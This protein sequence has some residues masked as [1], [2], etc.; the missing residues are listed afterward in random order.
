MMKLTW[1]V[2]NFVDA[3]VETVEF[4]TVEEFYALP[5]IARKSA[6]PGFIRWSISDT[7]LMAEYQDES[8]WAIANLSRKAITAL[9]LPKWKMPLRKR[10][11]LINKQKP[12]RLFYPDEE[13]V[14]DKEGWHYRYSRFIEEARV[15]NDQLEF[16][17]EGGTDWV[18]VNPDS[19]NISYGKAR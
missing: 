12:A 16:R 3:E 13:L 18:S 17:F 1:H 4:S 9:N 7:L 19:L 10:A 15:V 2:P 14:Y 11:E 5:D 8:F 6:S